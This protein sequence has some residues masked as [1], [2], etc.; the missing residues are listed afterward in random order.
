MPYNPNFLDSFEKEACYDRFFPHAETT[1]CVRYL[2]AGYHM[3]MVGA[4]SFFDDTLVHHFRRHYFQ[5]N[6]LVNMELASLLASRAGLP[7]R[8]IGLTRGM[9]TTRGMTAIGSITNS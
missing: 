3:S 1:S 8:W 6:L 2:F 7:K 9:K 4:G 5:I